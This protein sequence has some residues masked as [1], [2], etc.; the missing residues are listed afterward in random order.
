MTMSES[1]LL[2]SPFLHCKNSLLLNSAALL[3]VKL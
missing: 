2:A 3:H 1:S